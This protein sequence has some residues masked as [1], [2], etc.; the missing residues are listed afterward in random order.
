VGV[1]N[2]FDVP[3]IDLFEM[4]NFS[5]GTLNIKIDEGENKWKTLSSTF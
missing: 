3:I 4:A 2:A 5:K 1:K